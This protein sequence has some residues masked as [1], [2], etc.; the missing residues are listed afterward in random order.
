MKNIA[1][2]YIEKKHP[3]NPA[4]AVQV[5][6]IIIIT[7][8]FVRTAIIRNNLTMKNELRQEH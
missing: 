1:M 5:L 3:D 6:F 2:I 8:I 4:T 7:E